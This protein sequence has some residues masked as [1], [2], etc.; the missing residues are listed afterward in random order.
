MSK[1]KK[2]FNKYGGVKDISIGDNV[3]WKDKKGKVFTGIIKSKTKD[4]YMICCQKNKKKSNWRVS[5]NWESLV[6]INHTKDKIISMNKED[7]K[8]I[9]DNE[10]KSK[11]YYPMYTD[12]E[13]NDDISNRGEFNIDIPIDNKGC[14]K[15]KFILS[16]YQIFLK[17]YISETTPYNSM[18]IFHGTGVGKTCS[19]VSIAENFRDENKQKG[20]RIIIL[21]SENI[22]DGWMKNIY[23][24]DTGID[25]CT[26]NT[27]KKEIEEY[28][29]GFNQMRDLKKDRKKLLKQYYE[30]LGYQKFISKIK[31]LVSKDK[32]SEEEAIKREFSDRILIIDE[33]H[34][35]RNIG[36][37]KKKIKKMILMLKMK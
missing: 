24:I 26:G 30:F 5:L 2:T 35:I 12:T 1:I 13:F 10:T 4:N 3:E 28:K 31:Q 9:I 37:L 27:F 21:A 22:I 36:K 20:N 7:E 17:N 11:Y 16:P 6:K 34:N 33:A 15:N 29:T 19:G 14:D 8:L 25:Q 23:N 32:I 18:L